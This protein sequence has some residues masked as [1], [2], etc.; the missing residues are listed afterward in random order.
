MPNNNIQFQGQ[1]LPIPG[2]YYADNVTAAQPANPALVPPMVFIAFGFGGKPFSAQSF[3]SGGGQALQNALR[4]APSADFVPFIANPSTVLFG[5]SNVIYINASEN[6]QSSLTLKDNAAQNIVALKSADF[7]SPSNLLQAEVLTGTNAG[8]MLTLFDGFTGITQD[9]EDNL[10][11]PFQVAYVGAASGVTLSVTAVSGI[12]TP[13]TGGGTA[14]TAGAGASVLTLTSSAAG[15]SI[16]VPLGTAQ[17]AT[18]GQLVAYLNTTSAFVAQVLPNAS[19]GQLPTAFL[20]SVSNTALPVPSAG[21][22]Q[23]RNVTAGIGAILYWVNQFGVNLA[24]ASGVISG[25]NDNP[26]SLPLTHFTGAQSIPPTTGD[27][28]IAFGAAAQQNAWTVFAD[29]N[30]SAVV[31]LGVQHAVDMSEPQNGK[32]RR[33]ISGSSI[34]DT[35]TQAQTVARQ[36]NA[37]QATYVYPGIFR[38]NTATGN[39]TLYSGLHVAAAVASMMA[40]NL[41]A[42]PL[43]MQP[44]IGNGVEVNLTTGAGGQID[45]LQQAGVMPVYTNPQSLQPTIVS[46]MT[47]WNNDNNPENV[48]NQQVG[49]RQ[50]LAYSLSQGLQIYVGNIASPYGIARAKKAATKI[51]NQLIYSPGNN[52]ILVSFDPKSLVLTYNGDTQT[53]TLVVNVVFVGQIRFILEQ[54]F[55]QPLNLAA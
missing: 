50:A 8:V 17:Y 42:Q 52:G 13:I 28:A 39:N 54:T 34:G 38:T 35:V 37:Y 48:F 55:V 40:G 14:L 33:F 11:V 27:Y 43:T 4:G 53:L 32:W 21:N 19:N 36:M 20:D 18:V 15:E 46:D 1:T 25:A 51:L 9:V 23:F 16:T 10:G 47:T 24:S 41:I 44:L 49:C 3:P 26:A 31:A 45:L 2:S 22:P 6:T 5:A 30:N 7:G 29:S 12:G